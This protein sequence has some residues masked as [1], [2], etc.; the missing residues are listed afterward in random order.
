[1]LAALKQVSADDAVLLHACCHNPS[2][3][4]LNN[5][6]WQQVAEVA[7]SRFYTRYRYGIPRFWSR[8]R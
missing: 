2:G 3:M 6:Q 7:K 8:L 1:M 5:E 4:D